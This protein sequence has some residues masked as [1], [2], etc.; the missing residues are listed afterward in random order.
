M[1]NLSL[2]T[3]LSQAINSNNTQAGSVAF[4]SAV[5]KLPLME[6][7]YTL[8]G[9]KMVNEDVF[10][11]TYR[12]AQKADD[13]FRVMLVNILTNIHTADFDN[14]QVAYKGMGNIQAY[15]TEISKLF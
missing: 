8:K 7:Y 15:I 12:H 1:K 2:I 6:Q 14:Y 11:E 13:K 9:L 4:Y 3:D 5:I 10:F